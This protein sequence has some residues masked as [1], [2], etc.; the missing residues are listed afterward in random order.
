METTKQVLTR[1]QAREVEDF[2]IR[3]SDGLPSIENLI[4]IF[5]ARF[6][7]QVTECNIRSAARAVEVVLPRMKRKNS[8]KINKLEGLA[9]EL[10]N[11]RIELG[12]QVPASLKML[13]GTKES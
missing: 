11:L 12:S 9:Q 10:I 3:N 4:D 13:A 5:T 6:G 7:K 1:K 2:L 8:E